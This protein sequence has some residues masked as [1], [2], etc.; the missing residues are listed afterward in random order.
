MHQQS[1]GD[2]F[3]T[4]EFLFMDEDRMLFR[5]FSDD[6]PMIPGGPKGHSYEQ[7]DVYTPMA[8]LTGGRE[9]M[10]LTGQKEDCALDVIVR[11]GKDELYNGTTGMLYFLSADSYQFAFPHMEIEGTMTIAGKT[12]QIENTTAWFDRQWG[13]QP[14]QM[15]ANADAGKRMAWLWLGLVTDGGKGALSL[16]DSFAAEGHSSFCTVLRPDGILFNVETDVKYEDIWESKKTGNSYPRTVY[17]R[18]EKIDLDIKVVFIS[19]D[20]EFA[21][22]ALPIHGCQSL[23]KVIGHYGEEQFD[24]YQILEIINDLCGDLDRKN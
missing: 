5:N 16:W 6:G 20:P 11:P 4:A 22:E 24:N 17:I 15:I 21:R 8:R 18:S 13:F 2:Q 9:E 23:C 1:L 14:D 3:V 10:H 12:V 7:M 19:D